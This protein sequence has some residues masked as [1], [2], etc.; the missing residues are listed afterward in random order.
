MF[1][2]LTSAVFAADRRN[3]GEVGTK[4]DHRAARAMWAG[5]DTTTDGLDSVSFP[6]AAGVFTVAQI[7]F[8]TTAQTNVVF[9]SA[10][11]VEDSCFVGQIISSRSSMTT[12]T[13]CISHD[14][15]PDNHSQMYMRLW[16]GPFPDSWP[17]G[18]TRF[19]M[20]VKTASGKVTEVNT[21][22]STC[23]GVSQGPTIATVIPI[24]NG[25]NLT[26]LNVTGQFTAP[27]VAVNG[28]IL[29]ITAT[30]AGNSLFGSPSQG[31]IIIGPSSIGEFNL[32][33]DGNGVLTVCDAGWCSQTFFHSPT[34]QTVPVDGGKG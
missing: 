29:P 9:R 30:S 27:V 2:M 13:F 20:L 3:I 31:S 15:S 32:L 33:N 19:R 26:S 10:A 7:P 16:N 34:T 23:C 11:I 25:G 18:L 28:E 8:D 1:L 21:N 12:D 22:V 4:V 24:V 5:R 14:Q 17:S 6:Q